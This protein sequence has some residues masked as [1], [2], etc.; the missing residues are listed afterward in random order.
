MIFDIHADCGIFSQM[1]QLFTLLFGRSKKRMRPIMTD[2]L[3]KCE[4]YKT[5]REKTKGSNCAH[6]WHTIVPAEIDAK[7]WRQRSCTIGGNRVTTVMRHGEGLAG[8]VDKHGFH[9]HT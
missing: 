8:Y 4:N 2:I 3:T 9:P 6:G 1:A 5:Q 7:P